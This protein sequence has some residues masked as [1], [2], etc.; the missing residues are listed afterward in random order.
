MIE[1]RTIPVNPGPHVRGGGSSNS[2][3]QIS[4][5]MKS[6][7]SSMYGKRHANIPCEPV[8]V[9]EQIVLVKSQGYQYFLTMSDFKA[10]FVGLSGDKKHEKNEN[11]SRYRYF[12]L[13]EGADYRDDCDKKV[14]LNNL[15]GKV[16]RIIGQSNKYNSSF[17]IDIDGKA[18]PDVHDDHFEYLD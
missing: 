13:K 10:D 9:R 12:R 3:Y 6:G 18:Y 2:M 17:I 16:G 7:Q 14:S 15:A 4:I 5:S 11:T 1:K 8:K